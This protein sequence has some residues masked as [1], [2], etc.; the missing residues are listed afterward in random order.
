[1]KT[2]EAKREQIK[3]KAYAGIQLEVSSREIPIGRGKSWS[4]PF[5]DT[6]M[7]T[8]T[9]RC[10][11]RLTGETYMH[12][13]EEVVPYHFYMEHPDI[14]LSN[15]ELDRALEHD[16]DDADRVFRFLLVGTLGLAGLSMSLGG[17]IF[18]LI[19]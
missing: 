14:D 16:R 15:D 19:T 11:C 5:T 7:W 10:G 13:R 12:V 2:T 1:M 6:W 17:V 3:A 4:L 9:C 18:G 8:A